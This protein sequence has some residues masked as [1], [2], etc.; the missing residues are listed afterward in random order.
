MIRDRRI[1][2]MAVLLRAFATSAVGVTL[3][4]YL[5][6]LGLQGA[7]LGLVLSAGLAGAAVAAVLA[8]L[9][10]DRIGRRRFLIAQSALVAAGTAVFAYASAPLA[11]AAAA[12]VGMVNAM[13]RDRGAQPILELAA[14]PATASD[15]ERT[16]VIARYT[17]LQ[18]LG[19]ALGALAA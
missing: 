12:F 9:L 13:G 7:E 5:G 3:G 11:L 2:Y 19:G 8:T 16:T 15:A 14:L 6:R 1:L 4:A 10:A 18:D 17:M